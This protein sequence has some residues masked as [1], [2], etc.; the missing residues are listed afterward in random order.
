M[1]NHFTVYF[2]LKPTA[3]DG[4]RFTEF[5]TLRTN[6]EGNEYC[7]LENKIAA[8]TN[9]RISSFHF[10]TFGGKSLN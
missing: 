9:V 4:S 3:I 8:T 7:E 1:L 2:H 6:G 10:K 5:Q